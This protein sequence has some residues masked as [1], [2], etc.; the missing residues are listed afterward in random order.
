M[1]D[2]KLTDWEVVK[3]QIGRS[4]IKRFNYKAILGESLTAYCLRLRSLG[5][6]SERVIQLIIN[7]PNMQIFLREIKPNIKLKLFENIRISVSSRY[8]E[9][10]MAEKYRR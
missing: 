7:H 8:A 1:V 9:N 5:N 4:K 3:E 2:T 10:K 6:D